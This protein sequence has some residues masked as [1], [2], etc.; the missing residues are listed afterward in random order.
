M[1]HMSIQAADSVHR[2]IIGYVHAAGGG[3][4]GSRNVAAR[5]AAT[6]TAKA[7][8]AHHGGRAKPAQRNG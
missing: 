7:T 1:D 4:G 8:A 6:R 2:Q 3:G 5:A